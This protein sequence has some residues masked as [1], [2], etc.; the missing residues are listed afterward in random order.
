MTVK[1]PSNSSSLSAPRA[2]VLDAWRGGVSILMIIYHFCYDLNYFKMVAFDFSHQ[3][4]WLSFRA[5]IVTL[6][7]GIV[8][9]S[10]HLATANG[11]KVRAFTK[12]L[13]ILVVCAIL[14]SI[15]SVVLFKTRFIFFGIL[16]FIALASVLGLLFIRWF[17]FNLLG[18]LSLLG[19]GM[20]MQHPW[21][22]HPTL[23]WVGLMTYKPPTEDYVPL[24]PWFGIV[25]LGLFVGKSLHQQGYWYRPVSSSWVPH[26]AVIGQHSLLI[27]LAHQPL[28]MGGLFVIQ[29]IVVLVSS[30]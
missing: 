5:V 29:R 2:L 13:M 11:M 22:N 20:K 3:P 17:W 23:Q 10:L 27:Y 26:L 8:G 24:L 4:F 12:R 16:H 7:V 19:I 30:G 25:L 21:F 15:I 28:L 9:I 1:L 6:F 14:I 18:G